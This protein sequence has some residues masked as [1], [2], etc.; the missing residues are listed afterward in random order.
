[1]SYEILIGDCLDTLKTLPAESVNTCVTSPPYFWQRDYGHD[2][3]TG[4]E[5]TPEA[6]VYALVAVFRE[7]R[8]VLRHD[9]TVWLNLG[10][11]YYSGNGQ[12]TGSDPRS[13]S[14]NWIREKKRPL[15]TA[16]LGYPKK[17]LLG[18]P[19]MV[20][21]ALQS[22]GWTIRADIIWCRDTAFPEPSV[23][24]RPHRQHEYLF[25]I[26]KSRRYWF[27]RS[28]LP[29]ESVWHIG[30]QRGLRGHSAAFPPDL[31]KRCVLAGCP[32]G[33]TVL[34]PFG[35]SGTTAGVAVSH[36]RNAVLCELN[37]EYASLVPD[38]VEWTRRY[39]GEESPQETPDT[40]W[41]D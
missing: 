15:D 7:V 27:D 16:G 8:R 2:L 26:S 31:V 4:H 11:S 5:D 1:M 18:I 23:K 33:G 20:A 30:H 38:R 37:P 3:Q 6:F 22:D 35:G 34:D 12:P 32:E 36:G 17:S 14:R 28:D 13:P 29:E 39:Y 10:D 9:G 24:D 21:K 25:L 41:M 40:D 19:W